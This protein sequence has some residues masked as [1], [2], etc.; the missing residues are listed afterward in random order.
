MIAR[1]VIFDLQSSIRS[2]AFMPQG[3]GVM[4]WICVRRFRLK[5]NEVK[6]AISGVDFSP[7]A[8]RQRGLKSAPLLFFRVISQAPNTARVNFHLIGEGMRSGH[9][10]Q[11]RYTTI[12]A[13]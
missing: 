9:N 1:E 4:E 10:L 7:R 3:F 8:S 11:S 13:R 12:M 5:A 2:S 6:L